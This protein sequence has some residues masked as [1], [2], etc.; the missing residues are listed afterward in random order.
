[1]LI[2]KVENLNFAYKNSLVLENINFDIQTGDYVGL[3]GPN[4]GGKTTLVK[5]ILGILKTNSGKITLFD[6]ENKTQKSKIGYVPQRI[7]NFD[8]P[9]TVREIITSNFD[10]FANQSS[11]ITEKLENLNPKNTKNNFL[12]NFNIQKN[13]IQRNILPNLQILLSQFDP[14]IAQ[15]KEKKLQEILEITDLE[16][17]ENSQ[18]NSLSGGQLQRVFIAR[19]LIDNP[20][21]LI[22]DEPTVG[23]DQSSQKKFCQFLLNLQQ[24]MNLTILFISH[25]LEILSQNADYLLCVNQTLFIEKNP[26]NLPHLHFH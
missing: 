5:L 8:F 3:I 15:I 25:D 20:K 21:L 7:A 18:I 22:L 16:N 1:M 17:L 19:S 10:S 23:I 26:K 9:A 12:T 11:L 13:K 2:L 6:Q 14:K 4:G 24:K